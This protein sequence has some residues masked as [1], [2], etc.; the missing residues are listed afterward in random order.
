[1][2]ALQLSDNDRSRRAKFVGMLGSAFDGDRLNALAM[3]Q[4]MADNYKIPIHELLLNGSGGANSSFDRQRAE[5]AEREA[6]EASARAQRA[7]QA[8]RK[9]Q[10][11]S[12]AEPD[13]AM[14]NLPPNWRELF[15]EAQ[16]ANGSRCFL[17]SWESGFVDSLITH[18]HAR[19]H[20]NKPS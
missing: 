10:R 3:L 15:A 19:H 1:M 7:E 18:G 8:A 2:A 17:T 11:A 20:R 9:A 5:R 14:P 13:P 12:P 4:R 6:R 16:Q